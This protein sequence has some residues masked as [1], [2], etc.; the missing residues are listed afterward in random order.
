MTQRVSVFGLGYVGCVSAACFAK[1]GHSVIG[2]DVS[3]AKVDMLNAGQATIVEHGIAELVASVR[4]DGR[5]RATAD[6]RGAVSNSDISLICV[7]TPSKPN[8]S[9]DLSYVERVCT[10]IGA[11]L[12][13][14]K[15]RH[16]V[17]IRSTVLPGSTHDIAIPALERASGKKAG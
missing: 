11:V 13:D 3:Q 4:A 10:Q 16:T 5:L 2:V 8:G 1:E 7:G 15:E 12:R 9:L 14:K 17:V 6:V